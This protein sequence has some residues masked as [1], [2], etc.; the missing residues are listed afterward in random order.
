MKKGI[1]IFGWY[2][3]AVIVLAYIL[4]SFSVV[5]GTS[6]WYQILNVTG[7]IGIASISFYKKTYQPGVLNVIWFI[8]AVVAIVRIIAR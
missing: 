8:I 1:E 2:G 7:S 3:T 5:S 6:L 4:V